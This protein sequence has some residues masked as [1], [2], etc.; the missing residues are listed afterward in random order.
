RLDSREGIRQGGETGPAVV[1][2]KP[3]ESLLLEALRHESFEMPPEKK[4]PKNVIDDFE[5]WIARGAVDPRDQ[6]DAAAS[7]SDPFAEGKNHWSFQPV[8]N[9]TPPDVQHADRVRTPVDRFLLQKLEAAKLSY[10]PE[11]SRRV[12]IRRATFDLLGLPPTPEEVEQFLADESPAAYE[13]LIDRLLASPHYGE[14]WAR[15][16]LDV[17]RYADN[18]GYVFFEEKKYPWAWTYRDYVVRAFNEDQPYDR[19]VTEQLAA[20]R[21]DLGDDKRPLAAMGFLTLGGHFMNNTHDIIDDRID[22]VTRGLLGLT[23]TCA[24]CHDHKYD[25]VSQKEYYGLYGVFRGSVDPLLPPEF[26]PAPESEDY[27]KFKTGLQERLEKLQAFI[28]DQ[29]EKIIRNAQTRAG[30]YLLAVHRKRNQPNT[31]EFMLLTDTDDLHP[32]IIHRWETVVKRSK[33]ESDP[34]WSAW[35]AF[36]ALSDQEFAEQAGEVHRQLIDSESFV[37]VNAVVREAFRE[38]VP[39]SMKDVAEVY[40]EL[41]K[42][43][44]EHWIELATL[45]KNAIDYSR[46]PDDAE[47][48]VRQQLYGPDSAPMIP[49]ELSWGF[50]D[51]LPDRPTQGEF[52]KLLKEVETWSMNQPGAPPRAMVLQN[53]ETPYHPVVFIRGNP[54][55]EGESVAKGFLSVLTEQPIRFES[56]SGREELAAAIVA[57][58]NP[59]TARVFV[60]RVWGWHFGR[61]LV[62]TPSDFGLRGDPPTHPEL[63]DWLARDFMN[64][65]WSIKHLHRQIMLSG[66][67]RQASDR[68]DAERVATLDPKNQLLAKF[69]RTRLDFESTRDALLAASGAL[70]RT[71]GGPPVELISSYQPRRTLYGFIDRMDLPGLM[72]SFDYPDPAATS[73]EREQTTIV[74]QALF[75]MNDQFALTCARTLLERNDLPPQ[76]S[77]A[78]RIAKIYTI[79]FGRVPDSEEVDRAI[80]FLTAEAE[81]TESLALSRAWQYGYGSIDDSTQR[82]GSFTPL[83][84]WTGLRWQGGP[85]LPDPN[86]GWV[87]VDKRGGHPAA[88]LER[89]VIRRWIAPEDGTYIVTGELIHVPEPG[90]G[91]RGRLVSSAAGVLGEWTVD[92][93]KAALP[94]LEV[95]LRQGDTLDFVVDFRETI[96]HDEHEWPVTIRHRD[97]DRE[98]NSERDFRGHT[99][100]RWTELVHAL[101]M[102]NEF[103]FID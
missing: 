66:A 52:T 13:K 95:S 85:A 28:G 54:H 24:R 79:L 37:K 47:E 34:V 67:Y 22:V 72:R 57:K 41:F 12:L 49:R 77:A 14:R 83:T 75:F 102:T 25:P 20:D 68:D 23:V 6:P 39:T 21:L 17:A 97:D 100:D 26:L 43:V 1:P 69:P 61:G 59:L 18:K 50:L 103:V 96:L 80:A 76:D 38:R 64:H 89:C 73:P 84:H 19:F 4:L 86:L 11:A 2:G 65:G 16:W 33:R 44:R 101:M 74:P 70:D 62:A 45:N 8:R 82:V 36:A 92:Q 78:E 32:A 99:S 60:N 31:E 3:Q 5:H 81:E 48:A 29:R 30:E 35:H 53:A 10:A 58:E 63:L 98:W 9:V 71:L 94:E 15:H 56:G 91:V 7:E 87:F 88:T 55:R 93:S 51:L 27:Q 90:D 46:L 40:G 42:N